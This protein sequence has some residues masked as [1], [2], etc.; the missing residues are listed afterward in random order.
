MDNR[1]EQLL[2]QK[3]F[4]ELKIPEMKLNRLRTDIYTVMLTKVNGDTI[5][6]M[7]NDQHDGLLSLIYVHNMVH[8]N[9]RRRIVAEKS[10]CHE[11]TS[12]Q[13]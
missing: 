10:I 6:D 8:V 9:N 5:F 7:K 11:P 4:E 2:L 12:S 1:L 13:E 3:K